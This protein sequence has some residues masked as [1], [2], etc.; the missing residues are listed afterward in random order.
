MIRDL[1]NE[2]VLQEQANN[3]ADSYPWSQ[4]LSVSLCSDDFRLVTLKPKDVGLRVEAC[5][6]EVLR[7]NRRDPLE[8]G[9]LLLIP[10]IIP[11]Y[12]L[13]S[14]IKPLCNSKGPFK[15]SLP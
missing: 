1:S 4:I 14:L 15:G 5:N 11:I 6:H 13:Y 8:G 2:L 7:D 9:P 3:T 12:P 10:Y